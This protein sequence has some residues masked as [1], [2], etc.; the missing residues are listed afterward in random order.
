MSHLTNQNRQNIQFF[1][2]Q[3][4]LLG[5]LIEVIRVQQVPDGTNTLQHTAD[6]FINLTFAVGTF[7]TTHHSLHISQHKE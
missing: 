5:N 4:Q 6:H 1:F 3:F 2:Y 7:T